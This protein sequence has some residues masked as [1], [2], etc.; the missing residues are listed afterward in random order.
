M[1]DPSTVQPRPST[2]VLSGKRPVARALELGVRALIAKQAEDGSW[3]GEVVWSAMLAAEF[4]LACHLMARAID[5]VRS[6]RLLLHFERT[7]LATGTWGLSEWSEP[8]LFVTAIVYVAARVLGVRAEDALV[9]RA[10]AFIRKEGVASIP[11]W[12]KFWLAM[13]NLYGWDGVNPVSPE[14]WGMPRWMPIH[15]ARYYCHTRLIYMGMAALYGQRLTAPKTPFIEAL[16]LELYPNG[17]EAIDFAAARTAL[18]KGDLY[19]P[20]SAALRASYG[21]LVWLES[22]PRKNRRRE[23][24]RAL[25]KR[26]RHEL[27]TTHHTS[28]SPVSGLLNILALHD[29][30]PY[31]PDAEKAFAKL[32]DWIWED[33]ENGARVTGARSI[34]W[35]TSLSTQALAEASRHIDAR[36]AL[37]RAD[38]FLETQQMHGSFEVSARDLDRV[39][40]DGGYCFAGVWHGWPVSD[41]TAEAILARLESPHGHPAKQDV[42]AAVRFILGSQNADGGFGSYEPRRT[43]FSLEWLNPAEMFGDSMTESSYVEC[44]ASC[45]AG[46]AGARAHLADP[47][48]VDR[49]L[50]RAVARLQKAQLSNGAWLGAWGVRL[51]YGTLF[52]IRGLLAGG[53]PSTDPQIRSACEMLKSHQRADGGWGEAHVAGPS[54]VYQDAERS[55][56]IQTAW[57]LIALLA[58]DDPDWRAIERAAHFLAD[59]QLENGDFSQEEPAGVFFHTALLDYTLYKNYFPVWA[60]AQYETHRKRRERERAPSRPRVKGNGAAMNSLQ[61]NASQANSGA[62]RPLPRVSGGLPLVGHLV[63]FVRTAVKLLERAR[64]ECGDVAAFDVGP[65]KM[66]L[67]TGPKA[68]EAFFR[69]SDDVLNPSEAY[70]MMEPVFGKD[71]VYDAPPAKMAEQF[72]MLLPCLQDRRM[73]S[74]GEVIASEVD[75][76]VRTW[77]DEGIIDM[78]E[79]TKVL[80][81]FTS[82]TCLLGRRFRDEMT[83]EFAPIYTDLEHAI[84]PLAYLN[85]HLPIP[86]FRKR[87]RA[88]A[89]LVEMITKM[90]ADRRG[91]RG[92]SEGEDFLQ[93]LMET[94]YKSGESLSEHEITGLLLAAMF[95][96]HHTSAVTAAWMM[97]ELVRAPHLYERVRSELFRV[98]GPDGPVTYPSLREVLVT[99]GCV[100]ETLRMHPPL[101]MLMRVAMRDWEYD[102]YVIPKG[103]NLIVSPTVT[104]RIPELFSEPDR[105]DPDRFGPGRE[106]DK[107]PFAFQAFGGG[108]HKCL[109][110]AFALLQIK[111]VFAILMRRF[112]FSS[113]GDPFEPDFHG[114]VIGPKQPC[115]V[116]YRRIHPDEASRLTDVAR[117]ESGGAHGTAT[118]ASNGTTAPARCPVTG[119]GQA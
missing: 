48:I 61:V 90:I 51:V 38:R 41:C 46:L 31:D 49:P 59:A 24:L 91:A 39:E 23:A 105:F 8:S 1:M 109:G 6:R 45:I 43:R 16:R 7:R 77:G 20:P 110:N 56:V 37:E 71:V 63:P 4:V 119:I 47:E 42:E 95:A 94:K 72:S 67:L 75:R 69:A 15:P 58:A 76:S 64:A 30:D 113:C 86:T 50:A 79:Y 103:T 85:A 60:L 93:I 114:I 117:A 27:R 92:E 21:I 118:A 40:P 44:T 29:A 87:D 102:G 111:T 3:E 66:V 68:S 52:G 62:A 101:F 116:R 9:A 22:V 96:G 100:K 97:L 83:E 78:Y 84:T 65:K 55:Q 12:G 104:H 19:A 53:V 33:D 99:E 108:S 98:Y 112:E 81:N 11:S 13:M 28:I 36:D 18:R 73:R 2:P 32:D 54:P 17:F 80:T 115:R 57:A 70:K 88:R 35:D 106:E 25:R 89:L 82:S 5:S 107:R 14:L 74:Y 34:T 10:L 26:I